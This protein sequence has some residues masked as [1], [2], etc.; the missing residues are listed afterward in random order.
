MTGEMPLSRVS[1]IAAHTSI[2]REKQYMS[3][4]AAAEFT[5]WRQL[6]LRNVLA[7][8]ADVRARYTDDDPALTQWETLE[9]GRVCLRWP[10]RLMGI[11]SN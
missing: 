10:S 8:L 11:R 9:G 4:L 6:A 1:G 3:E 7:C 5:A 2:R